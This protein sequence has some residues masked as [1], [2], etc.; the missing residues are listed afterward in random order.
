MCNARDVALQTH[1]NKNEHDIM[2]SSAGESPV[3]HSKDGV[4]C[5]SLYTFSLSDINPSPVMM[6]LEVSFM[7]ATTEL[8]W[9]NS[10]WLPYPPQCKF[11]AA[12]YSLDSTQISPKI[13]VHILE[14]ANLEPQE[15]IFLFGQVIYDYSAM[16][17]QGVLGY[18]NHNCDKMILQL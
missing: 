10:C 6:L 7:I 5:R 15:T 4:S 13:Y 14:F 11:S 17:G 8:R 1:S 9:E 18:P 12:L 3:L 16:K 2:V